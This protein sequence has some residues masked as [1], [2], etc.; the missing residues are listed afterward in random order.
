M[1][2]SKR[3]RS[4][5]PEEPVAKKT[6]TSKSSKTAKIKG[7]KGNSGEVTLTFPPNSSVRNKDGW[8][9]VY[10]ELSKLNFEYDKAAMESLGKKE[11]FKKAIRHH[12]KVTLS[13][14][15]EITL[16]RLY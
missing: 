13:I 2:K 11:S 4:A 9:D 3:T 1:Q 8:E 6:K 15:S 10:S 7:D 12:M 16:T 5:P 14:F